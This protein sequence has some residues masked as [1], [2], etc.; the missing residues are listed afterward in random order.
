MRCIVLLT[1]VLNFT[2]WS[3]FNLKSHQLD[4][5]IIRSSTLKGNVG[6]VGF[7]GENAGDGKV[8]KL[9][10]KGDWVATNKGL[11]IGEDVEDVQAVA[12]VSKKVFLAGTWKN[13]LYRTSNGGKTWSKLNDFPSTDIRSI[14]VG[15]EVIY[16][17]TTTHGIMKS[18]DDGRTWET[19]SDSSQFKGLASWSIEIHPEDDNTV[20][21]MTF[22]NGVKKSTDTGK[23]W[24]TIVP[25]NGFMYYDLDIDKTGFD[26]ISVIGSKDSTGSLYQLYDENSDWLIYDDLPDG[27]L[28]EIVTFGIESSVM[29]V[30]SW[31][32]GVHI[33]RE[34]KWSKLEGL[35]FPAISNLIVKDNILYVFTWGNGIFTFQIE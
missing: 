21:A 23:T 26:K 16:A 3:Q 2:A 28:K 33:Y 35:D 22:G 20:Y 12:I 19:C 4:S 10:K 8:Y 13:G 32:N 1:F 27:A 7:K 6:L 34:E 18:F 30:G 25:A 29:A 11:A 31:G 14:Q 17:A 15:Q 9:D 5:I 24:V